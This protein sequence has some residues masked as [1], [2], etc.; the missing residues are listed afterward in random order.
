MLAIF[1]QGMQVLH[2]QN[3]ATMVSLDSFSFALGVLNGH[4]L[5][6]EP[7]DSLN[8]SFLADG[9]HDMIHGHG[10]R[11]DDEVRQEAIDYMVS[12]REAESYNYTADQLSIISYTIGNAIG[13]HLRNI[14]LTDVNFEVMAGS[15]N[16]V[17][18]GKDVNM[19]E[20]QAMAVVNGYMQGQMETAMKDNLA[21]GEAFL[22][23]NGRRSEVTTLP[24]GLQY[25]II[26]PGDGPKPSAT[27]KVRV[28]YEGTLID[29]TV[30]D[31]SIRRGEPIT[32]GLDQVIPGW[33]E[34]LQQMQV[35]ATY[36]LYIP[37]NLAY[38]AQGAGQLIGPGTALI[39][40]VELL[41]IE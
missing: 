39:F 13:G 17:V 9:I 22:A 11:F 1:L 24:S 21:A 34:G 20:E 28:H 10:L 12:Q 40:T 29:G 30:F 33:T 3:S 6:S 2:A 32:F 36:K 31:S 41:G 19:N 18:S 15:I 23:E 5:T 35:G 37:A 8:I 16:D 4:N 27:D 25:E 7:I 14:G 38:G 26:K